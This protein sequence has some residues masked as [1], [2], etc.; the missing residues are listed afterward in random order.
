MLLD[1]NVKVRLGQAEV[2]THLTL[3]DNVSAGLFGHPGAGKST[4]LNLIANTQPPFRQSYIA[5]DGFRYA[6]T[7]NSR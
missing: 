4:V 2:A 5:I 6:Q 7:N 3:V 1:M